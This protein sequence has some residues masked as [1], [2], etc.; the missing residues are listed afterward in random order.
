MAGK[1]FNFHTV[2]FSPQTKSLESCENQHFEII[3]ACYT[4]IL[5]EN[6]NLPKSKIVPNEL[7]AWPIKSLPKYCVSQYDMNHIHTVRINQKKL[8]EIR[9]LTQIF[10]FFRNK[11]TKMSK[12]SKNYF[13]FVFNLLQS[14]HRWSESIILRLNFTISKTRNLNFG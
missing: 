10:E 11:S 7:I 8:R 12:T 5:I 14:K 13:L 6:V 2:I 4:K 3:I 9:L 1:F